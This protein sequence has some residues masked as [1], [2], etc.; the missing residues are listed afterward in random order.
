[1]KDFE[2]SKLILKKILNLYPDYSDAKLNLA[3]LES[4]EQGLGKNN[5]SIVSPS[6][7]NVDDPLL[8]AFAQEEVDY[9]YKRYANIQK[10]N[11]V[12]AFP[13]PDINTV[14]QEQLELIQKCISANDFK[15]ALN[16]CSQALSKLGVSPSIYSSASDA[17]LAKESYDKSEL[18]LL[19]SMLL[20][21]PSFKSFVN[22]VSFACMRKDF[23]L[24]KY[25]L[26][27]AKEIDP[28][29]DTLCSL[30]DQVHKQEMASTNPFS[31]NSL[32]NVIAS[33]H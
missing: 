12:H 29:S 30:A 5:E 31:F 23:E 7:D 24:A 32:I 20:G 15:L 21:G 8:L 16:L 4:L 1:M 17:L 3:R 2:A 25:Y 18:L 9:S 13:N 14:T 10:N 6:S 19:H 28:T 33:Y 11:N 27:K 22:L 26:K